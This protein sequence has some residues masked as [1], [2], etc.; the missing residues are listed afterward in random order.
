M[1]QSHCAHGRIETSIQ[2]EKDFAQKIQD[3]IDDLFHIRSF[4]KDP[5]SMLLH[6]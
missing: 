6:S 1:F 2:E 4:P 5:K 3:K